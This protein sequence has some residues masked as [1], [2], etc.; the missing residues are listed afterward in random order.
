MPRHLKHLAEGGILDEILEMPQELKS[1]LQEYQDVFDGIGEIK[2]EMYK[3]VLDRYL[4]LGEDLD[5]ITDHHALNWLLTLKG[6]LT[7]RLLRWSL[8]NIYI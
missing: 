3:I 4:V 5:I 1:I 8:E 6:P 7:G 2:D